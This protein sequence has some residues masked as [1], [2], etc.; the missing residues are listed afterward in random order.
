MLWIL[1]RNSK[2]GSSRFGARL[3]Q[4]CGIRGVKIVVD[5]Y[6]H[7]IYV[8]RRYNR[9]ADWQDDS[10]YIGYNLTIAP[11]KSI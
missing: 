3:Y 11:V 4:V 7:C 6:C 9:P 5:S 2:L 10:V 8:T 1:R